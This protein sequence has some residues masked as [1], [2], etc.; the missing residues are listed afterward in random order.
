MKVIDNNS[1]LCS[2]CDREIRDFSSQDKS[3]AETI[4]CGHFSLKQIH[5]VER[6]FFQNSFSVLTLSVLSLLG[7]TA[8]PEQAI[9]QTTIEQTKSDN[10]LQGKVKISG[11]VKDKV[12]NEPIPS[13]SVIVKYG[14]N[15]I[16]GVITDFNGNFSLTI[17]TTRLKLDQLQIVFSSI[18]YKQDTLRTVNLTKDLLNKEV[19]ISLEAILN[20]PEIEIINYRLTGLI[21]IEPTNKKDEHPKK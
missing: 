3:V 2:H 8:I 12:N 15:F 17:D 4:Y 14:D 1:R 6:Q 13:V 7:V 21:E 19:T 11:L 10:N 9:G 18:G 5:K 16:N 20:L